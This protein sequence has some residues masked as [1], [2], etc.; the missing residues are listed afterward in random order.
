M[1]FEIIFLTF[2]EIE[3]SNKNKKRLIEFENTKI[4]KRKKKKRING[5]KT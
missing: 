5:P 2:F 4:Y 1:I 3:L